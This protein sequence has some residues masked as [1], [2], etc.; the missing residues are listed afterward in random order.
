MKC[1]FFRI[2]F[3]FWCNKCNT[4]QCKEIF[5]AFCLLNKSRRPLEEAK[6]KLLFQQNANVFLFKHYC[7]VYMHTGHLDTKTPKKAS[8][9]V[10]CCRSWMHQIWAYLSSSNLLTT[11]LLHFPAVISL[12]LLIETICIFSLSHFSITLLSEYFFFLLKVD[13]YVCTIN[14]Y[15][16]YPKCS[17]VP[18][19][20]P[21]SSRWSRMYCMLL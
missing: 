8:E 17:V 6:I 5:A 19:Q 15:S 13:S 3:F 20:S 9:L 7:G 16:L 21:T 2:F 4:V 1:R 18:T 12:N 10:C 14:P 11:I